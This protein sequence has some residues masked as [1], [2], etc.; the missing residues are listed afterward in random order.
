M[1]LRRSRRTAAF[2]SFLW[3]RPRRE[4]RRAALA[5]APAAAPIAAIPYVGTRGRRHP[6]IALAA[7]PF[8]VAG[9]VCAYLATDRK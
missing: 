1:A 5:I 6:L 7:A 4:S 2:S 3:G 9:L 8:I